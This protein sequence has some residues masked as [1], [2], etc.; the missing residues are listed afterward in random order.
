[1]AADPPMLLC[2][3][4]FGAVDPITRAELQRQFRSLTER[5]GKTVVFVTHDVREAL[6]LADR[7]AVLV[8]GT[9]AFEGTV[10]EFQQSPVSSVRALRELQ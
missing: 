2:D 8:D 9:I 3:E 10:A 4:A 7:V 1:M 5:L 6:I